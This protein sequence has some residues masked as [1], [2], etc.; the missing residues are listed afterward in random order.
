M[1][2]EGVPKGI[3]TDERSITA[4]RG[5]NCRSW[6]TAKRASDDVVSS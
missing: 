3:L 2:S 6:W 5:P 4:Q 1:S